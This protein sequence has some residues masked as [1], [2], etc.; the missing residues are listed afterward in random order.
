MKELRLN[1]YEALRVK[2]RLLKSSSGFIKTSRNSLKRCLNSH[3]IKRYEVL[4]IK[5]LKTD[6]VRLR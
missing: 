6:Y 4:Y 5:K 2:R 1:S 3:F